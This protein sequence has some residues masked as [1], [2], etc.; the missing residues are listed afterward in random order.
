M[1]DENA[2]QNAPIDERNSEE[3]LVGL[4]TG[5]PKIFEARMV[6]HLLDCHRAHFLRHQAREPFMDRHAQCADTLRTKS[7]GGRQHEVGAIRFQQIRRANI[8]LKPFRDQGDDVHERLGRL[9]AFF[10][11]TADFL[12]S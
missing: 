4:F 8:G 2:L 10:R 9:A 11:E 6:L 5:F 12:Q 7:K 1:D 3:R